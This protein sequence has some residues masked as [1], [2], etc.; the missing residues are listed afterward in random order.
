VERAPPGAGA[1]RM[2]HNDPHIWQLFTE[3]SAQAEE[4]R[5]RATRLATSNTFPD[6]LKTKALLL[7]YHLRQAHNEALLLAG[8]EPAKGE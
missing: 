7:A 4:M 6:G 5:V 3:I 1:Y 2:T 8:E